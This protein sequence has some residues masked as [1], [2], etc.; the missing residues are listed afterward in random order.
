MWFLLVRGTQVRRSK[1][2]NVM[3]ENGRWVPAVLQHEAVG[4]DGNYFS[5]AML[6]LHILAV[7]GRKPS[8]ITT[9]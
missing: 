5:S 6:L 1:G 3:L 9:C 7:S 4:E 8:L 2:P